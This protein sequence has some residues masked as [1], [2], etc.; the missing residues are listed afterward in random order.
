MNADGSDR[1]LLDDSGWSGRWSPDGRTIAYTVQRGGRGD[2]CLHDVAT[3]QKRYVFGDGRSPYEIIYWSFCWSPDSSMLCFLGVRPGG[4]KEVATVSADGPKVHH[5]VHT[6]HP[7]SAAFAW[8]PDGR[9]VLM[10]AQP[11]SARLK[12]LL[13]FSIDGAEVPTPLPDLPDDFAATP[14]DWSP[15]GSR[16]AF[17]GF[18]SSPG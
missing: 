12:R 10:A 1:R 3:D 8:H 17:T 9:R 16:V 7:T 4:G 14:G 11:P 5:R 6:Q 18:R 15:D 2:I 13:T